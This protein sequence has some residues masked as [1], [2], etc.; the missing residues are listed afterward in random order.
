MVLI[1]PGGAWRPVD[2][3]EC[4]A[5]EETLFARELKMRLAR[6]TRI[7]SGERETPANAPIFEKNVFSPNPHQTSQRDLYMGTNNTRGG[8]DSGG[9]SPQQSGNAQLRKSLPESRPNDATQRAYDW[10]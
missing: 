6:E 9:N 10:N 3:S 1:S 8:G 7:E 5:R 4:L 2:E